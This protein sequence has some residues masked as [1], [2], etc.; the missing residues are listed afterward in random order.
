M[1]EFTV[2]AQ[3]L[4]KLTLKSLHKM[5]NI[6]KPLIEFT[7][8]FTWR[9]LISSLMFDVLICINENVSLHKKYSRKK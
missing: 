2:H 6:S 8:S 1:P 4:R 7:F 3:Y 5:E 9:I